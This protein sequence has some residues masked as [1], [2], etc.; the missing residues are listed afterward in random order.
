MAACSSS[1]DPPLVLNERNND[2]VFDGK[3]AKTGKVRTVGLH[4]F[5]LLAVVGKGKFGKVMQVR[6]YA[7]FYGIRLVLRLMC[8]FR[9]L[10]FSSKS[11]SALL[12]LKVMHKGDLIEKEVMDFV[13]REQVLCISV[14]PGLDA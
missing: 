1:C 12:A 5:H 6:R 14:S 4:D 3:S 2:C 11:D 8:L 13:D 10:C 9:L 7:L